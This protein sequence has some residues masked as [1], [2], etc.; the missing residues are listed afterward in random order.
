M[1]QLGGWFGCV[2]EAWVVWGGSMDW[3]VCRGARYNRYTGIS[4]FRSPEK[5]IAICF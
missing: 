3:V 5:R 1:F 4:R 2:S